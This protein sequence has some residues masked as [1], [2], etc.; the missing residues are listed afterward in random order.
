MTATLTDRYV[1][2]VLRRLPTHQRGDVERELRA[3]IADAVDDR[4]AAG[5]TPADAETAVLTELGDPYRLA[6]GYADRPLYL[7]GPALFVDYRRVLTALL[8]AVVPIVTVVV[9]LVKAF[10]DDGPVDAVVGALGAG[11]TTALH[12]AF[13][14][15]LAFAAIERMPI[16]NRPPSHTWTPAE[17]PEPPSR[18]ARLGELIGVS[19]GFVLFT[20]L[21][22]FSRVASPVSDADGHPISVL[23]PW[24]WDSGVMYVFIALVVASLAMAYVRYY[25]RWSLPLAIGGWIVDI[26]PPSLLIW[27]AANDRLVNPAFIEAIGW[28]PEAHV[29]INRGII[30]IGVLSILSA[31]FEEIKRARHR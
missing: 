5:T 23:S 2:A 7:I 26:A 31:I 4:A 3:S 22:L 29:W 18:R 1:D 12:I 17:L 10:G 30:A 25:A 19:V 27:L 28:A 9:G 11:V 20:S 24:V 13:W 8:A 16:P 15:T 6:A 21:V 14:T